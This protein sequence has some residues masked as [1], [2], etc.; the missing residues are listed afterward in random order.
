[1][2]KNPEP[3]AD[4]PRQISVL[5]GPYRGQRLTV[6]PADADQAIADKWARDAFEPATQDGDEAPEPM[7]DEETAEATRK[8]EKAARK[9]R[10]EPEPEGD[11]QAPDKRPANKAMSADAPAAYE[12][13]DTE[14]RR[15]R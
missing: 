2:A 4:E 3:P 1:M 15:R 5:Y 12:T 7:T 10:G 9:M 13:R 14:P 11:D 6:S 8:A